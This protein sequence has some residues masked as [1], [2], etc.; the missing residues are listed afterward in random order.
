MGETSAS[1]AAAQIANTP[2]KIRFLGGRRFI[3]V[4]PGTVTGRV[5]EGEVAGLA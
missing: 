4:N 2:G 1:A 5:A 3:G